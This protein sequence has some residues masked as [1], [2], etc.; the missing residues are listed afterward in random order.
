[1]PKTKQFDEALVLQKARD[2]FWKKGYNATSMDDLVQ[3]TGLSR[4][5]IYDTFTDKHGLYVQALQQ[6]QEF[7]RVGL[8]SDMPK[9]LSPRKK[10]EWLFNK[11]I[12]ASM[13]D[14]DRKGCFMLN[15]TTEL[16]N[17]DPRISKEA[18]KNLE[19]ME[20]L[21]LSWIKEGQASGEISKKFTAKAIA[22]HLNSSF[23]GLKLVAQTKP[24]KDALRD[25]AKISL[26]VLDPD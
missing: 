9:G 18:V 20:L 26:S 16:A 10:I 24:D 7:Q 3:A 22:H 12:S 15:S 2:V 21:F 17:M 6:Y 11:S 14:P 25:I 13:A 8:T 23:N 19:M 4:S 5:S 1:M